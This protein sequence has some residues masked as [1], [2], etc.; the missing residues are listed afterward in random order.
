MKSTILGILKAFTPLIIQ[1]LT[2]AIAKNVGGFQ[3]WLVRLLI[4]YG[5][6]Q[7]IEAINEGIRK[8]DREEAQKKAYEEL[9]KAKQNP[10]STPEE[11]AK[12]GEAYEKYYNSGRG[13]TSV[14]RL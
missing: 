1:E 2:K 9:E 12:L 4:K 7:L 8:S 6:R 11:I 5:G 14:N 13:D 10:A 3:F